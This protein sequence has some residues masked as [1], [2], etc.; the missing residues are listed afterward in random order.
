MA[1]E[2]L[3]FSRRKHRG[4]DPRGTQRSGAWGRLGNT[5]AQAKAEAVPAGSVWT[6]SLENAAWGAR[7]SRDAGIEKGMRGGRA[8]AGSTCRREQLAPRPPLVASVLGDHAQLGHVLC[9]TRHRWASAWPLQTCLPPSPGPWAQHEPCGV[10]LSAAPPIWVV[11]VCVS[12]RMVRGARQHLPRMWCAGFPG[13]PTDD[14]VLDRKS[15][16]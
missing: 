4:P 2:G 7:D 8:T 16:V 14:F 3:R 11:S 1:G 10:C 9:L 15:V 13:G 12:G 5:G 6:P